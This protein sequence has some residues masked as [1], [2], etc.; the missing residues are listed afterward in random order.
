M[1][2]CKAA[3]NKTYNKTPVKS[4]IQINQALTLTMHCNLFKVLRLSAYYELIS[5]AVLSSSY[6]IAG[7]TGVNILICDLQ[8]KK[9]HGKYRQQREEMLQVQQPPVSELL[10]LQLLKKNIKQTLL[11]QHLPTAHMK[12]IT[13]TQSPPKQ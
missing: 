13:V 2:S 6:I 9:T 1:V 8:K 12:R 7:N 4:I 11:Q 5:T 3:L 10:L